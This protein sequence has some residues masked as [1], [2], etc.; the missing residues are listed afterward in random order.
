MMW[1]PIIFAAAF[2]ALFFHGA[3][4]LSPRFHI[5]VRG[6]F[7][8]RIIYIKGTSSAV[9]GECWTA[10]LETDPFGGKFAHRYPIHRLGMVKLNDDGTGYYCGR[11]IWKD[12]A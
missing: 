11:V 1:L 4:T 2:T 8:A 3:Y 5:F 12:R 7:G 6:L 10:I 9:D